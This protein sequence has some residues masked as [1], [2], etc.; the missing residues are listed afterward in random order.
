MALRISALALTA[1]ALLGGGAPLLAAADA[2]LGK[3]LKATIV[4]QGMACDQLVEAKRNADSDYTA[5]CKDGNR[6][7]VYVNAQ[8]RVIVQKL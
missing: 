6:Y 1:A 4:L 7:H 3:D 5:S 2:S 8:G